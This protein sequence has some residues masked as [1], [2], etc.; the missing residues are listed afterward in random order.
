MAQNPKHSD[1]P[2]DDYSLVEHLSELRKRIIYSLYAVVICMGAA[3]AF[4]EHIFEF[5]RMPIKDYLPNGGLVFTAPTDKFMAYLK[6][7][8]LAGIIAACPVWIYNV[9]RFVEPGLY[10]KEKKYGRYFITFGVLLFLIGVSFAYF[11][12]L[13]AAFKVLLNFGDKVDTPMI[14]ISEYMSFFM[15]TILIFGASFEMPLI[16]TILGLMGIVSSNGLR[17]VRRYAIVAISIV[18]AIFTPPDVLSMLLLGIPL[19]I[20]YEISILVLSFVEPKV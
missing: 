9:W 18:A 19:W 5:V 10:S 15:T 8:M 2:Q 16:L 17:R 13:P 4:S 20:L 6:L 12:V 11:L 3:W 7:S 14:T 1:T